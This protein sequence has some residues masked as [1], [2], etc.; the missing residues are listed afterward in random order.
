MLGLPE[1]VSNADGSLG[2]RLDNAAQRLIVQHGSSDDITALGFECVDDD[3]LGALLLRLQARGQEVIEADAPF[4][5][6][7]A[8]CADCMRSGIRTATASSFAP[9]SNSPNARSSQ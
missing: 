9:A 1:P 8:E 2:W 7:P 3:A 5:G 4:G 6:A